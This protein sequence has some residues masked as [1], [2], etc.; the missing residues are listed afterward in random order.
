MLDFATLH[1]PYCGESYESAVDSSAGDQA[2]TE[3]CAICCRPIVVTIR[4]DADGLLDE[5]I[6]RREQD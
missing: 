6:T 2:Y 3:D 1:C 4:V 5:V